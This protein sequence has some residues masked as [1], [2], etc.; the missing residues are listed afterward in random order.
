MTK[1]NSR[2]NRKDPNKSGKHVENPATDPQ[3]SHLSREI[4]LNSRNINAAIR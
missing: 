3:P 2:S 1:R 4:L